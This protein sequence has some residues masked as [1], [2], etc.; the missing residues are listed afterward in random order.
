MKDG[1]SEV[2]TGRVLMLIR[3]TAPTGRRATP[4]LGDALMDPGFLDGSPVQQEGT[5]AEIQQAPS[6]SGRARLEE[7]AAGLSSKNFGAMQAQ[8]MAGALEN[9]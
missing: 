3:G 1:W 6:C 8:F 5:P 4:S 2:G 9:D 7:T